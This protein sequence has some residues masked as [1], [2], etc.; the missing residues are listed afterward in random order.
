VRT[1]EPGSIF[2]ISNG[3]VDAKWKKVARAEGIVRDLLNLTSDPNLIIR[4]LLQFL[5]TPSSDTGGVEGQ[6]FVRS[7]RYGTRSSTV[8]IATEDEIHFAER[9]YSRGGLPDGGGVRLTFGR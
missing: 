3:P 7:D 8:I 6:V 4:S 5:G 2:A 9:S 1:I